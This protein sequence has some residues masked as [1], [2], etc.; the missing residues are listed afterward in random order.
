M[1]KAS[2]P[3]LEVRWEVVQD[4]W[5]IIEVSKDGEVIGFEFVESHQNWSNNERMNIYSTTIA[6]GHYVI[7]AVPE[8]SYLMM[9]TRIA[10]MPL[11]RPLIFCFDRKGNI[12][13]PRC[14]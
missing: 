1:I 9:M 7:V 2:D 5:G 14:C 8:E 10:M 13:N 6:A 4:D 3:E 12:R 11:P